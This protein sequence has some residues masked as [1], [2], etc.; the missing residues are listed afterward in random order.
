M[1]YP[2]GTRSHSRSQPVQIRVMNQE[3]KPLEGAS[4]RFGR[5]VFFGYARSDSRGVIL[6]HIARSEGVVMTV[7]A[8]GYRDLILEEPAQHIANDE[9][10]VQLERD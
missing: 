1:R 9:I 8:R 7:T 5:S 3:G 10:L 6:S 2:P 4:L